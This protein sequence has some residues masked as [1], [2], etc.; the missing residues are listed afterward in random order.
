MTMQRV[1]MLLEPRQR[2]KLAELAKAQGKSVAEITRQAIDIGIEQ[3]VEDNARARLLGAL[4][5]AQQLRESM[6]QRNGGPLNIDLVEEF[7][8]MREERD[9]E[10]LRRSGF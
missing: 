1:Q 9:E 10:L 3:I 4:E 6:R 2:S 8:Q 5:A 7:R